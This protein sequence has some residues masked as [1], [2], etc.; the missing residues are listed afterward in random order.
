MRV[1]L[2]RRSEG[3]TGWPG[4]QGPRSWPLVGE[5]SL[6]APGAAGLHGEGLHCSLDKS[7]SATTTGQECRGRAEEDLGH[8]LDSTAL[9]W[10]LK[11]NPS[12]LRHCTWGRLV[13]VV[14]MP[15]TTVSDG[16]ISVCL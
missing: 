10:S 3:S 12:P 5:V 13:V 16:L 1:E 11:Q 6:Q 8:Q 15:A 7:L 9:H 2:C 14:W 4:R